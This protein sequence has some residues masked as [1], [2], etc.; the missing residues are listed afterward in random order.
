MHAHIAIMRALKAGK[1][2]PAR[3][4]KDKARKA[5]VIR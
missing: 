3:V 4:R 2:A 5:T 1:P